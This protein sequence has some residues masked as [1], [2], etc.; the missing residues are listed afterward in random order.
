MLAAELNKHP[1]NHKAAFLGFQAR[2]RYYVEASQALAT[3]E[4]NESR[5]AE[6][7]SSAKNAIDLDVAIQ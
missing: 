7:L 4:L 5:A 3:M 6:L 2:M 1:L